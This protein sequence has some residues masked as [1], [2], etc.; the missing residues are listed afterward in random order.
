VLLDKRETPQQRL[1][2]LS[3]PGPAA[4]TPPVFEQ[5]TLGV[6][7][8]ILRDVGARKLRL[9]SQPVPYRTITGFELEVTEFVSPG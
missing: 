3:A 6:G 8:Q 5:R 4:P 7:A 1:E 9:L 2:R